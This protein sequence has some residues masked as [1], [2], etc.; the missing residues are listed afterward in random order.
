VTSG[1]LS[2]NL[3]V[4]VQVVVSAFLLSAVFGLLV[5]GWLGMRR[6]WGDVLG[7]PLVWVYALP[8][9]TIFPVFLLIFGL[10]DGSRV[11]FGAFHGFF[12]LALLVL[13]GI[14]AVPPVYLRAARS[15]NL[16]WWTT[17]TRV[18]LPATLPSVLSGL[19]FCFSLCF[20]GVVLAE[21]FGS[22][23]G[24]GYELVRRITLQD[25]PEIFALALSLMATA[26]VLNLVM[27]AVESRYAHRG[28]VDKTRSPA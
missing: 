9:I 26:F 24:A 28:T 10:G 11:A 17:A 18:V 2:Y 23:A 14:R 13:S 4:T 1:W 12:P 19:R 8:K 25:L 27:L 15:L 6:F 22:Q 7:G 20:L 5:G 16:S 3:W 21:M